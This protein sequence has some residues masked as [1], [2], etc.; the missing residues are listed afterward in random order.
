LFSTGQYVV[1][2]WLLFSLKRSLMQQRF[3]VLAVLLAS[4]L[5][6][7]EDVVFLPAYDYNYAMSNLQNRSN[8]DDSSTQVDLPFSIRFAGTSYTRFYVCSNSYITFGGENYNYDFLE[9]ISLPKLL[10]D[11]T[12]N[13]AYNITTNA[14]SDNVTIYYRGRRYSSS[15]TGVLE[16]K[17]TFFA[18]S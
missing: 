10:I 3:L 16:W 5:A 8:T 12:D 4:S 18:G 13:Y 2:L 1:L 17:L 11:A 14:T 6:F 7:C 15:I 9:Q